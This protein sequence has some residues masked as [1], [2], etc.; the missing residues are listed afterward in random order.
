[1]RDIISGTPR[2]RII[3]V[4]TNE[5]YIERTGLKFVNELLEIDIFSLLKSIYL[6]NSVRKYY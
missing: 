4:T 5:I 2:V 1:M 6:Y 3:L